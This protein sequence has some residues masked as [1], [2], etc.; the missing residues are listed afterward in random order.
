MSQFSTLLADAV[1]RRDADATKLL[2]RALNGAT[3]R[4]TLLLN[5][6]Q[7]DFS[8]GKKAAVQVGVVANTVHVNGGG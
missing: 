1:A 4:F 7:S 8:G 6:L 2:D 3:T 5:Q